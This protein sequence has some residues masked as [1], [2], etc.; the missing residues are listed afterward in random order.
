M[1]NCRGAVLVTSDPLR[2][3]TASPM[4]LLAKPYTTHQLTDCLETLLGARADLELDTYS[5][6]RPKHLIRQPESGAVVSGKVTAGR[7]L[8]RQ[9]S[10][11]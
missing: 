4:H 3:V 10:G 8:K 6:Q 7:A 9:N 1:P 2:V 11:R 5:M